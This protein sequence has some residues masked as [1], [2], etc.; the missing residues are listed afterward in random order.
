MESIGTKAYTR[1]EAA[2]M[3]ADLPV[4]AVRI[5]PVLTYYDRMTRFNPLFRAAAS[6]LAWLFGGNRVGWFLTIEFRKT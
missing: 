6:F 2:R 1:S 4:T 5:R 3:L